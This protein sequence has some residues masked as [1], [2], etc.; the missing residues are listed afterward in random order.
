MNSFEDQQMPIHRQVSCVIADIGCNDRT[1]GLLRDSWMVLDAFLEP[2]G[3]LPD[4][5]EHIDPGELGPFVTHCRRAHTE[6]DS[7]LITLAAI[8]TLLL[9]AG[10][11]A[12]ALAAL[13]ARTRR[14]RLGNA[15][16]GKYVYERR[17]VEPLDTTLHPESSKPVD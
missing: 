8:R 2:R 13:T 4:R 5:I 3:T 14:A 7:L 10:Y 6:V 16:N 12:N 15:S 11:P 17:F 1:A 9:R